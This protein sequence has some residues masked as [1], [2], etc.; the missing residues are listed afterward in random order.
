MHKHNYA[1]IGD[2]RAMFS[3]PPTIDAKIIVDHGCNYYFWR[4][5]NLLIKAGACPCKCKTATC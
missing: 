1:I 3:S 5:K 2:A 4:G